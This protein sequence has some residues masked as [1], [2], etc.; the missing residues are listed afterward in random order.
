VTVRRRNG[1]VLRQLRTLYNVGT[2]G[3]LTD[4]Q[5]LEH[6]ATSVGEVAE[7]AFAALVERH[8]AMVWTTCLA[9]VRNEHEAEDAFQATFLVLVHKA[10]SLWVRDSLGPWLHQVAC[11]TASCLRRS[12][13]RRHRH[14][15]RSALANAARSHGF[16]APLDTDRNAA[17]HEELNRL[18]EKYRAPL[19]LCDLE[20]RTHR[21]A[22][23]FLGWP[24]GTVKSRQS[25][26]RGLLRHRLAGRGV[27]LAVAAGAVESLRHS[28]V[29]AMPREISRTT[30]IAVMQQSARLVTGFQVSSR[31]L[32]LTHGVLRAMLWTRLRFLAVA[33]LA[34]GIASGGTGFYVCGSQQP[35]TEGRQTASQ[36]PATTTAP[37][38]AQT[39]KGEPDHPPIFT[40]PPTTPGPRAQRLATRKARA[41]YEIAKLTR[42]LAEIAVEEYG[43]VNFPREVAKVAAE[44]KLAEA[45]LRRA[46]DQ[47]E[48][49]TRMF[50]KGYVSAAG[51]AEAEASL[52]TSVFTLEQAVGGKKV[53]VD[54]VKN[55][56]IK[57]LKANVE[58]ARSD[59]LAR[60]EAWR[61]EQAK[62]GEPEH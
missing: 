9:I 42:E 38:P 43:E 57:E 36:P 44:I 54:F 24:I 47:L 15:R 1:A 7:L 46:E 37:P 59:E 22:A 56:T 21:E 19:I 45:G 49:A 41:L 32:T 8:Q 25:Q 4:G 17:I 30:V 6:F 27:G 2:I 23:R 20:G 58:K 33:I 60:Q 51:K 50:N 12:N 31:V 26:G 52:K 55:K 29:A 11:R 62:E 61:R 34:V 13:I 28:A 40:P 18:P 53:L 10:R 16:Q 35:A 5:L 14:E 48:W 39:P 3:G